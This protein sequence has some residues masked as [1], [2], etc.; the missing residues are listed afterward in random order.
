VGDADEETADGHVTHENVDVNALVE[1]AG[2][3]DEEH[4]RDWGE[5]GIDEVKQVTQ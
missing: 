3:V 2:T 4:Y 1:T 5:G